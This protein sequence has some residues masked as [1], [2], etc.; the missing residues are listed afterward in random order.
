MSEG[1]SG[2]ILDEMKFVGISHYPMEY[3]H[4]WRMER[5]TPQIEYLKVHGWEC[6][7]DGTKLRTT[8]GILDGMSEGAKLGVSD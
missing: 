7:S 8:L 2:G 1:I 5:L 3:Q 6:P 4:G